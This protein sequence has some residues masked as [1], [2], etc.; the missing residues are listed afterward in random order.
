[1]QFAESE[2]TLE[3]DEK[4]CKK[5]M[6]HCLMNEEVNP[7]SIVMSSVAVMLH[8]VRAS[9][10]RTPCDATTGVYPVA[11][12]PPFSTHTHTRTHIARTREREREKEKELERNMGIDTHTLSLFLSFSTHTHTHTHTR[13]SACTAMTIKLQLQVPAAYA[14]SLAASA[15]PTGCAKSDLPFLRTTAVPASFLNSFL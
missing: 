13:V 15:L 5:I 1:M 2:Q 9:L 12:P 4:V 7:F 6:G 10:H 8:K 14:A 11:P 3:L